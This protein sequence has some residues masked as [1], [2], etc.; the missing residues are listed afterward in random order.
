MAPHPKFLDSPYDLLR[1]DHRWFPASEE[2]RERA[3]E[4][5]LPRLLE[6]IRTEVFH[7]P[8]GRLT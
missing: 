4:K 7:W 2:L 1:P 6:N 8:R 5:L 3:Y